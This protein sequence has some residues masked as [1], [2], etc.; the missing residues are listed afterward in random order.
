MKTTIF[1]IATLLILG[2]KANCQNLIDQ[3]YGA[4]A[5]SFE[6]GSFSATGTDSMFLTVGATNIT[7]WIVGTS[8]YGSS[9]TGVDWIQEPS[10]NAADGTRSVD[11]QGVNAS[12]IST[13]F[14]T[15]EGASYELVLSVSTVGASGWGLWSA[16]DHTAW[17]KFGAMTSGSNPA[18]QT[19]V[20]QTFS[21][22]ATS[23]T[24]TLTLAS[25][26][27]GGY[28]PVIDNVRVHAVPEPASFVLL[29]GG[30]VTAVCFR[31]RF[32]S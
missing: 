18:T 16:G 29:I 8:P 17:W 25:D 11:L 5:G 31:R 23:T 19:F 20:D 1:L 30:A 32:G 12:S 3:T 10:Y 13:S 4:G 26:G 9:G 28:G 7:G 24:T 14:S 22:T 27:T 6:L 15:V 2:H 21:F